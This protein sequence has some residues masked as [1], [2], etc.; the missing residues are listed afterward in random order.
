MKSEN[1]HNLKEFNSFLDEMTPGFGLLGGRYFV[2]KGTNE[3]LKL[4]EIVQIFEKLPKTDSK[5]TILD[6]VIEIYDLD[7]KVYRPHF[8]GHKFGLI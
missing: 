8:F 7:E 6:S 4:N 1:I 3:K 5:K 2:E